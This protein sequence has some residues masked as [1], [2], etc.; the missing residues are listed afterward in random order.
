MLGRHGDRHQRIQHVVASDQRH[1]GRLP[2]AGTNDV[3]LRAQHAAQHK[4]LGAV[5]ARMLNAIERDFAMKI[6]AELRDIRIVGVEKSM[7]SGGQRF[8]QLI[9]GARNTGLRAE[10]L[11]MRQA[12]V[13][14]HAFVRRCNLRQRGDLARV[15][16]AHLDHR[17]L[18]LGLQAQQ[19]HRKS[20]M[21]VQ[22]SQRLQHVELRAQH[23]RN[24]FLG[25]GLAR[26]AGHCDQ[27]LAPQPPRRR[28]QVLQRQ[29][30]VRQ[31]RSTC[32]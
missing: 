11:Q 19:L 25:G 30:A 6:A 24:A 8:D 32:E 13:G 18:V 17:N 14:H 15:R 26:R 12:D 23:M 7:A 16:H 2:E 20:K 1:H 5:V 9:L 21:I 28:A 27:L 4:I 31:P 10:A 22:I 3:K 29:R